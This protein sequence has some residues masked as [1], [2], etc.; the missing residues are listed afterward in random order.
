MPPSVLATIEK[1]PNGVANIGFN[2]SAWLTPQS[3][4]ILSSTWTAD[5]GITLGA[6]GFTT[7][8]TTT[9]VSGG[10]AGVA[11]TLTNKITTVGGRVEER[12]FTIYIVDYKGS[13]TS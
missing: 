6:A 10:T 9:W 1:T 12:S 4:T 11:Y 7:T 2:Y 5:T 13:T 3:D 8:A